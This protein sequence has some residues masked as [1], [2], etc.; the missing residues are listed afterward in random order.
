MS[1]FIQST[2]DG[3]INK[4]I[5]HESPS[6]YD[7]D[8]YSRKI[9]RLEN[10][11]NQ[12]HEEVNKLRIRLRRAE[13]FELKYELSLKQMCTLQSDIDSK[14]K[15]VAEIKSKMEHMQLNIQEK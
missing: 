3:E 14:D 2:L 9:N 4:R 15:Q 11:N 13:D 12:I 5:N 6:K 7:M 1:E 10:D 8:F